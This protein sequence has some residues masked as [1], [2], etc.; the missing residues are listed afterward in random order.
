[1]RYLVA[2]CFARTRASVVQPN[3][4]NELGFR[5][6]EVVIVTDGRDSEDWW[7]GEL[8]GNCGYF[9]KNHVRRVNFT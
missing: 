6:D 8:Q 9:P 4:D 1:M 7:T 3:E 2:P 5:K